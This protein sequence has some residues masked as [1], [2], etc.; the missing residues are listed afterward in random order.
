MAS[1]MPEAMLQVM[2]RL[3]DLDVAS[4]LTAEDKESQ[5][6]R[7]A[8]SLGTPVRPP[9]SNALKLAHSR[10]SDTAEQ[11][12]MPACM[13]GITSTCARGA[14]LAGDACMW[15]ARDN[16]LERG[17]AMLVK[18]ASPMCYQI[19]GSQELYDRFQER[20]A[21]QPDLASLRRKLRIFLA[22]F[23]QDTVL[24][25]LPNTAD[26]KVGTHAP[27]APPRTPV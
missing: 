8:V 11:C 22:G 18:S 21:R 12:V 15:G 13:L 17:E 23:P 3:W 10:D 9:V 4:A 27:S 5:V 16:A 25:E 14:S 1:A 26:Y 2:E 19:T 7:S 6:N 24:E 20:L